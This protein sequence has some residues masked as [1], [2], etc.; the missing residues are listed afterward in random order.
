MLTSNRYCG[1]TAVLLRHDYGA[2]AAARLPPMLHCKYVKHGK[3]NEKIV[4]LKYNEK[5]YFLKYFYTGL[6][7]EF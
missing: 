7:G 6:S 3:Y 2:T 5:L 1:A 4:F